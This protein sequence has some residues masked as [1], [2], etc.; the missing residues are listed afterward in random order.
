MIKLLGA[1]ILVASGG[2]AGMLVAWEYSKKP[3]ELKAML[4]AI[5]I[6]ETEIMYTATP[7]V[8][9]MEKVAENSVHNVAV[10]FQK[11]A[12]ELKSMNGCT[13][14]EAWEKALDWYYKV[15]SLE[16]REMSIL[17]NLGRALGISDQEDQ[18]KH[19]HLASEQLKMEIIRAEEAA[20]K[21]TKM[22]NYLGF[23]GSLVIAIILY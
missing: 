8:E 6:L 3:K 23:C 15:S 14:G 17:S 5:K 13:A 20:A 10:F 1:A 19:L 2:F 12:D 22:W 4:S 16:K 7:M 21:N 11:A 18:E 9:A